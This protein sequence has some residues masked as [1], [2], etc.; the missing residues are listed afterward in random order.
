MLQKFFFFALLFFAIAGNAKA[1][2]IDGDSFSNKTVWFNTDYPVAMNQLAEKIA[3]V[4]VT[5]PGCVECEYWIAQL[6]SKLMRIAE[7]QLVQL[8]P[9]N[10][11]A[12]L[13]RQ[14]I[15]QYIQENKVNHPLGVTDELMTI[16][17]AKESPMPYFA[18]YEMSSKQALSGSGAKGFH[19]VMRRLDELS[20]DRDY[21]G[22]CSKYI[23][24]PAIE[25]NWWADPL[26]ENPGYL[27]INQDSGFIAVAEPAHNRIV[28][29]DGSGTTQYIIG[30]GASGFRDDQLNNSRFDQTHGM[31]FIGGGK[32]LIADTYNHKIRLADFATQSVYNVLGNGTF[33]ANKADTIKG[34]RGSFGLPVDVELF[35]KRI[36]LASAAQ[37]RLYEFDLEK[38]IARPFCDLPERVGENRRDIRPL[39]LSASGK[40][41]YVVMNDGSVIEVDTKGITKEIFRPT[42]PAE[43]VTAVYQWKKNLVAAV[44]F[45]NRIMEIAEGKL[46]SLA[47]TG[48]RGEL[49]EK[50]DSATFN[51]P[52][53]L[54][55]MNGEMLISDRG[56]FQI[57]KLTSSN[58]GRV[59]SIP[60]RPG[61]EIIGDAVAHETGEPVAT[62][63]LFLNKTIR[64]SHAKIKL[65]LQGYQLDPEGV[66]AIDMDILPGVTM[67]S[68]RITEDFFELDISSEVQMDDIYIEVYLTLRHPDHP[69]VV[70]VKRAFLDIPVIWQ[71][72]GK[73]S[74][75]IVYQPNLLPG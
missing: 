37:N 50:A 31:T 27:A 40:L 6:Q 73:G 28:V 26:I 9:G 8:I 63:T 10:A 72:T 25:Q 59:K 57:R 61:I 21:M 30:S 3:I 34:V 32:M 12:P 29:L 53:D 52:F 33:N 19:E 45:Q 70:I 75:D 46:I 71:E 15:L 2:W 68:E 17:G 23:A 5:E 20:Q 66:S 7:V 39:N 1:Q 41:L 24:K 55:M 62:D 11:D 48:Q 36:I 38:G 18:L 4:V 43:K 47:G 42:S 16:S 14:E 54:V 67:V 69:E 44:P 65:D 56:N 13:S 22:L 74:P 64:T 58:G 49:N 51:R 35:G 60:I